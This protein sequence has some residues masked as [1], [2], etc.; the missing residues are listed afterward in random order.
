[1]EAHRLGRVAGAAAVTLV[2]LALTARK[3]S[4]GQNGGVVLRTVDPQ[5]SVLI[6]SAPSESC[7]RAIEK[8][9]YRP[10]KIEKVIRQ[11]NGECA[12]SGIVATQER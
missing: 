11:I 10:I 6:T 3:D 2:F 5:E 12:E 8:L 1:M 9:D 7:K 4:V